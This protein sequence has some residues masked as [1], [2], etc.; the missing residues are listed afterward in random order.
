MSDLRQICAVLTL[1]TW[2]VFSI[3]V[4]QLATGNRGNVLVEGVVAGGVEISLGLKLQFQHTVVR[5]TGP[6]QPNCSSN[7]ADMAT[8]SHLNMRA[9]V[10]FLVTVIVDASEY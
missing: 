8:I 2:L 4:A 5:H 1:V 9:D 6:T 3:L 7:D 10:L